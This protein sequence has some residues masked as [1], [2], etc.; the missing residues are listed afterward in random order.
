VDDFLGG[1]LFGRDRVPG[2]LHLLSVLLVAPPA[3]LG[4]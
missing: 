4:P 2:W 3:G 1:M